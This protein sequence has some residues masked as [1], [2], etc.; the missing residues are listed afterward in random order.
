M[1]EPLEPHGEEQSG[2]NRQLADAVQ[3]GGDEEVSGEHHGAHGNWTAYNGPAGA[4]VYPLRTQ[5][6][7]L[8]LVSTGR[9]TPSFVIVDAGMPLSEE[10]IIAAIND[11]FGEGAKPSA[12]ILT[13][14]HFDHV[15][16][17]SALVARYDVPVY[18][19]K[20]ELPY[21]LGEEDY[22][23]AQPSVG[24]GLMALISP[25]YPRE[26]LNLGDAV[27][28]LP[29]DGRVPEMPGWRWIHT[30]GHT[31]GHVS[32]YRDSDG[33]LIAGDAFTTV[34]QESLLA[35]LTQR[36]EIHGPPA[37]FTPDWDA[38]WKSVRKLS[39]LEPEWAVTGHGL[40]ISGS[41]LRDGLHEL[42]EHFDTMAIPNRDVLH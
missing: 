30:P 23:P 38:A 15:G 41:D 18:A 34:R 32:F 1:A 6:A 2:N 4:G 7:N 40:A 17:L 8:C 37:Y 14:G 26:A 19:H 28:V 11:R 27:H 5:I 13:H 42:A 24:G 10:R 21:L 31:P 9:G 25:M 22:P 29:E 35:I 36:V 20:L 3:M 16:S 39:A 12:I 33:T